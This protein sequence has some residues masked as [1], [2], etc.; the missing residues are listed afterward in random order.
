MLKVVY[1]AAWLLTITFRVQMSKGASDISQIY[2]SYGL[3]CGSYKNLEREQELKSTYDKW[4]FLGKTLESDKNI[5]NLVQ[6][7]E[8]KASNKLVSARE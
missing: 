4:Q 3:D 1:Y 2:Q 6:C 7:A 5:S 8:G